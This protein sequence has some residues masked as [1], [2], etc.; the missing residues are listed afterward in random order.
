MVQIHEGNNRGSFQ[1]TVTTPA[2]VTYDPRWWSY[3][4]GKP[5]ETLKKARPLFKRVAVPPRGATHISG[6]SPAD[7]RSRTFGM[8]LAFG[9]TGTREAIRDSTGSRRPSFR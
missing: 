7:A 6:V 8:I 1:R 9:F 3:D 2:G 5:L 4:G